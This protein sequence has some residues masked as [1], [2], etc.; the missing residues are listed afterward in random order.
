M[1][2]GWMNV[3]CIHN[4]QDKSNCSGKEIEDF[5]GQFILEDVESS[6]SVTGSKLNDTNIEASIDN[7]NLGASK[8][9]KEDEVG[10]ATYTD[11]SQCLVSVFQGPSSHTHTHTHTNTQ[12]HTHTHNVLENPDEGL[13]ANVF[14]MCKTFM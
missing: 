4:L 14:N 3:S 9:E 10:N 8:H 1:V 2:D 5:N 13:I 6:F 12:V 7:L 11:L